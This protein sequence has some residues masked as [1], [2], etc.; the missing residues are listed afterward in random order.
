M[1]VCMNQKDRQNGDEI[2]ERKKD[3]WPPNGESHGCQKDRRDSF[4]RCQSLSGCWYS[5]LLILRQRVILEH[6]ELS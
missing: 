5:S 1:K 4:L 6:D 3:K 2:K